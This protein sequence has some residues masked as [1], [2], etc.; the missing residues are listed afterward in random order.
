LLISPSKKILFLHIPRTAGSSI[1]DTL[2]AVCP[3]STDFQKNLTYQYIKKSHGANLFT[4][5]HHI[6]Q[7]SLKKIINTAG[8]NLDDYFE[9]TIVRNPYERLLSQYNYTSN[10]QNLDFDTFLDLYEIKNQSFWHESQLNWTKNP[11][12]KNFKYYKYE[13]L[14]KAWIEIQER[15][16]LGLTDLPLINQ[17]RIKTIS[18]LSQKQKDRIY[19]ILK[20]EFEFLNYEK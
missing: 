17:T 10:R 12:T 1:Y 7:T 19:S 20:D 11:I 18:K 13:E 2:K 14:D 5:D 6:D 9:F 16:G 8:L 4:I 15:T 3:D